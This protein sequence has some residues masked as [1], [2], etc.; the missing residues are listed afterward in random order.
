MPWSSDPFGRY[1]MRWFEEGRPTAWVMGQDRLPIRDP[2]QPGPPL[3]RYVRRTA[4]PDGSTA[5]QGSG[6]DRHDA[7]A[8]T[9]VTSGVGIVL[10]IVEAVVKS[11]VRLIRFLMRGWK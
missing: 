2:Q 9:A 6:G 7:G 1:H 11:Y 4:T 3:Q 10:A 5:V 8:G